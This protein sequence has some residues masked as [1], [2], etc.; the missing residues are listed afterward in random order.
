MYGT[1]LRYGDDCTFLL[2][3]EKISLWT[4][5]KK[6]C[7]SCV[8]FSDACKH[9][10]SFSPTFWLCFLGWVILKHFSRKLEEWPMPEGYDHTFTCPKYFILSFIIRTKSSYGSYTSRSISQKTGELKSIV[11]NFIRW[12]LLFI[13]PMPKCFIK[14]SLISN[15]LF[16]DRTTCVMHCRTH[17]AE[18][19]GGEKRP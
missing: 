6:I 9:C 8:G 16:S 11:L 3:Q 15:V 7:C 18:L 10:K 4:W 17:I 19:R 14:Y 1:Y 5:R 12:L 13:L 2:R